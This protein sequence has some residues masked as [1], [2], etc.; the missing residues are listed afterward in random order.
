M[1]T[2]S[3]YH[4][5]YRGWITARHASGSNNWIITA[6]DERLHQLRERRVRPPG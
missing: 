4:W 3:I 1:P 2:V 6:A 5:I